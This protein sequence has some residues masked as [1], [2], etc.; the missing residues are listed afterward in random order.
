M[1]AMERLCQVIAL[2]GNNEKF[3]GLSSSAQAGKWEECHQRR[4]NVAGMLFLISLKCSPL[5]ESIIMNCNSC[6]RIVREV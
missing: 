4:L 2:H 6:A 1:Y 3:S 5:H